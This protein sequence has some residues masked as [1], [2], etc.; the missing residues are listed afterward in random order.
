MV[1]KDAAVKKKVQVYYKRLFDELIGPHSATSAPPPGS[2]AEKYKRQLAATAYLTDHYHEAPEWIVAYLINGEKP[3]RV[4]GASIYG[5]VQNMC[6]TIRALGLGTTLTTRHTGY[7]GGRCDL[8]AAVERAFLRDLA[9]WLAHGQF[10]PARSRLAQGC[11]LW[12]PVGPTLCWA[13]K[14]LR[15]RCYNQTETLPIDSF[16]RL[17]L[18]FIQLPTK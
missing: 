6:L 9:D 2:N 5:A 8:R 17:A 15:W 7:E 13:V 16:H 3:D 10:R 11:R 12:R 14:L 1:V 18:G 4:A